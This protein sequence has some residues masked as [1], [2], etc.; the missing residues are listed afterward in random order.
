MRHRRY[1]HVTNLKESSLERSSPINHLSEY[2]GLDTIVS[3]VQEVPD[4]SR[5]QTWGPYTLGPIRTG[6]TR[7]DSPFGTKPGGVDKPTL[8]ESRRQNQRKIS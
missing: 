3:G 4:K 5:F 2:E 6:R 1:P 7:G 8:K